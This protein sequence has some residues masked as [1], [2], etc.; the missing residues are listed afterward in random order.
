MKPVRFWWAALLVLV[1]CVV[2]GILAAIAIAQT[3]VFD[4]LTDRKL[5]PVR[6]I[7]SRIAHVAHLEPG[8]TYTAEDMTLLAA[9]LR[10]AASASD[11]A[12]VDAISEAAKQPDAPKAY[13]WARDEPAYTFE[14]TAR[15]ERASSPLG[16]AWAT[17]VDAAQERHERA[18]LGKSAH[19]ELLTLDALSDG[20]GRWIGTGQSHWFD[21]LA[22]QCGFGPVVSE[23][24]HAAHARLLSVKTT[25]DPAPSMLDATEPPE[26]LAGA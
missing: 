26:L 21:E 22:R 9:E 14:E 15:R 19:L 24:L 11:F 4:M 16:L 2:I 12:M 6:L 17:E 20:L 18:R 8:R 3:G 13:A 10:E 5:H 23:R 7:A 1:V 25:T